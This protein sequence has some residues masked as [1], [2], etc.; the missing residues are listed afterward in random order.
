MIFALATAAQSQS[1]SSTSEKSGEGG[2]ARQ[3]LL[4]T[5]PKAAFKLQ[6]VL[7]MWLLLLLQ[8]FLISSQ[9]F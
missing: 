8:G 9:H 5:F 6:L 4:Q 3:E 7:C 1:N 2:K